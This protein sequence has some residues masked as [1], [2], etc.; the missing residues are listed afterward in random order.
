MYIYISIYV[1][2]CL[3]WLPLLV[4]HTYEVADT[5]D[6]MGAGGSHTDTLNVL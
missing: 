4:D 2:V 6:I 5:D 1:S 3:V